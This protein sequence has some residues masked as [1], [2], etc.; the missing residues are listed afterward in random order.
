MD[1]ISH[2]GQVEAVN[3]SSVSVR[4]EQTSAC[5]A[6][7]ARR[8]CLS[9]DSREKLIEALSDA[10]D[11]F[12]VGETVMVT[13]RASQGMKAVWWAYVLPLLLLMLAVFVSNLW[14]FPDNEGLGALLALGVTVVY[15]LGLYLMRDR[16]KGRFV[17]RV[18]H[19][20][21]HIEE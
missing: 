1:T 17:F 15:Y 20:D 13:G 5:S 8:V 14:L 9:A 19:L 4:I 2:V 18:Q 3:Q 16:M 10:D 12:Q 7:H 11:T 21:N 6:C